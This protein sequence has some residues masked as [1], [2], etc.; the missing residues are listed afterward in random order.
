MR[1]P[2]THPWQSSRWPQ[3]DA[4][5]NHNGDAEKLLKDLMDHP[6]DLVSKTQATIAYAKVIGPT[7]PDDARKLLTQILGD[8]D[9]GNLRTIAS[10]AMSAL[11]QK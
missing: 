4:S 6:T 9:S 8:K 7:R 1:K 3:M 11:P 2:T 10:D 5:E